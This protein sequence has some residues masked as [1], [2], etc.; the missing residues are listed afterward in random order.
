M[1]NRQLRPE[2][3]ALRCFAVLVVIINH[4]NASFLPGGYIGVDVFFVISGFLITKQ[5]TGGFTSKKKHLTLKD[6][7]VRRFLRLLPASLFLLLIVSIATYFAMP[8]SRTVELGWEVIASAF[9]FQNW[10]LSI[11][12]VNYFAATES[13]SPLQHFWSLCVEEQFYLIWPFLII[14]GVYLIPKIIQSKKLRTGRNCTLFLMLILT[15]LSLGYAFYYSSFSPN[16]AYFVTTT[17][18]WELGIGGILSIMIPDALDYINPRIRGVFSYCALFSLIIC[19]MVFDSHS[20]LWPG[21]YTLIPCF[22]TSVIIICGVSNS[23]TSPSF[24]YESLPVLVMGDISYSL[25]LWHFPMIVFAPILFP[26]S[27]KLTVEIVA[28]I[29]SII[30]AYLSRHYI[31]L[32]FYNPHTYQ[33]YDKEYQWPWF[34]QVL[35]LVCISALVFVTGVVNIQKSTATNEQAWGDYENMVKQAMYDDHLCFG[36]RII[37][38][39]MAQIGQDSCVLPKQEVGRYLPDIL[40]MDEKANIG[41]GGCNYFATDKVHTICENLG[42][43]TD[44]NTSIAMVGDSKIGQWRSV[45]KIISKK[46]NWNVVDY[47]ASDCQLVVS[48]VPTLDRQQACKKNL[49]YVLPDIKSGKYQYVLVSS[50][51][52]DT[53]KSKNFLAYKD[54]ITKIFQDL[55]LMGVTVIVIKDNYPLV[56]Q[57]L[58]PIDF[59]ACLKKMGK[60]FEKCRYSAD[61]QFPDINELAAMSTGAKIIDFSDIICPDKL[62]LGT[63]PIIQGGV[64]MFR[65]YSH[66]SR[67]YTLSLKP[68]LEEK[69]KQYIH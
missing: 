63:C 56:D 8:S 4:I 66:L 26:N 40:N 22:L 33:N 65:D 51:T 34:K 64:L 23:R 45:M 52:L 17:R 31:E 57:N 67:L 60:N 2:I 19:A 1:V 30:I 62:T 43:V 18:I 24:L 61:A 29:I 69:L 41:D 20:M 10:I 9:Y 6:F 68:I 59:K 47:S 25:Y 35:G 50:F 44:S 36:A 49:S 3:Q 12:A 58:D 28:V 14:V 39:A 21:A 13:V 37:K 46:N 55:E 7:Y 53:Y 32:K 11:N 16:S 5:L 15:S 42:S 38:S 27:D 54:E 48:D